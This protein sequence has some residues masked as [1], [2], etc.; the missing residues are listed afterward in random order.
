M[1]MAYSP[2]A[3]KRNRILGDLNSRCEP[4]DENLPIYLNH[5]SGELLGYADESLGRYADAFVFHLSE[6]VCKKLST[7]S[8]E[9]GLNY[10]YVKGDGSKPRRVKLNFIVLTPR[11]EPTARPVKVKPAAEE[12]AAAVT[13]EDA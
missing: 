13:T 11:V 1:A 4:I 2:I 12:V 10:D 3:I 5:E 8:Y 9:C 7:N 6:E